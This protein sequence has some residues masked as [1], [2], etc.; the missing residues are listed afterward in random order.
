MVGIVTDGDVR[1]AMQ[2]HQT[3]FFKLLVSGIANK[4]PKT[5]NQDAKLT[6]AE[7]VIYGG[8]IHSLIVVNND[9]ELMGVIDSVSCVSKIN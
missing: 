4:H 6:E 3:D 7:D 5:I 1:R 9:N 2:Q 8:R